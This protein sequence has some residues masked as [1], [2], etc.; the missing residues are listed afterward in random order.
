MDERE[1][2][3]PIAEA[4]EESIRRAEEALGD[5][6]SRLDSLESRAAKA[7][8]RLESTKPDP[9]GS[10]VSGGVVGSGKGLG[11]GLTIAYGMIGTP[12]V[13]YFI[14]KFIDSRLGTDHWQTWLALTGAGLGFAWIFFVL[15]RENAS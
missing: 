2:A 9:G 7:R 5:M 11:V 1:P 4:T 13:F 12:L 10:S 3:D 14:G 8:G 15:R 6:D